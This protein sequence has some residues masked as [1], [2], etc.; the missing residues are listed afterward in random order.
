MDDSE[1]AGQAAGLS[2]VSTV[3][4]TSSRPLPFVARAS[5]QARTVRP[6][7]LTAP[8][9]SDVA[10]AVP[11]T[12]MFTFRI[13]AMTMDDDDAIPPSPII[14]PSTVQLAADI[15]ARDSNGSAASTAGSQPLGSA[16]PSHGDHS[17]ASG[18]GHA[19]MSQAAP[20]PP[21]PV[22]A[23][24][25][26]PQEEPS[27]AAPAAAVVP[28]P[29]TWTNAGAAHGAII[30]S[31]T[32]PDA[33]HGSLH[34]EELA[35]SDDDNTTSSHGD[36]GGGHGENNQWTRATIMLDEIAEAPLEAFGASAVDSYAHTRTQDDGPDRNGDSGATGR[37]QE[38][39]ARDTEA[40]GGENHDQPQGADVMARARSS[41]RSAVDEL[42][43]S[44]DA[45][46]QAAF[47]ATS[48]SPL[49]A[50][51][52]RPADTTARVRSTVPPASAPR[53]VSTSTPSV[54]SPVAPPP[55]PAGRRAETSAA[56]AARAS[57][58]RKALGQSD[59]QG[60]LGDITPPTPPPRVPARPPRRSPGMGP[61]LAGEIHYAA[62]VGSLDH[63]EVLL[64]LG[65]NVNETDDEGRTPLHFAAGFGHV[66]TVSRLLSAGATVNPTDASHITPLWYAAAEGDPAV[67]ECLLG[68]GGNITMASD[69]G[70]TPL[71]MAAHSGYAEVV[72]LFLGHPLCTSVLNRADSLGFSPLSA[73]ALRGYLPVVKLLV[74]AGASLCREADMDAAPLLKAVQVGMAWRAVH[75]CPSELASSLTL[76]GCSCGARRVVSWTSPSI[77]CRTVLL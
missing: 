53:P 5:L 47:A 64:S 45:V 32:T 14:R 46:L 37:P 72:K 52:P 1:D 68:A 67:V 49:A 39:A 15:A 59:A 63:L 42:K 44:G 4:S 71:F 33:P 41:L 66:E 38:P 65:A 30:S 61:P 19:T 60:E 6:Q 27:R 36:G 58:A 2:S 18:A 24:P 77:C 43:R 57:R 26:L 54:P 55:V 8:A 21:P 35:A 73:A 17:S 51:P 50:T 10:D 31:A 25:R 34:V 69:K 16:I 23:F 28:S 13:P 29:P 11:R 76:L 40:A 75:A 74:R 20:P 3:K 12:T 56:R 9:P 22:S 7:P 70:A 48:S 62:R